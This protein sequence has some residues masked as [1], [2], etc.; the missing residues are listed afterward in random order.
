MQNCSRSRG[1]KTA[2]AKALGLDPPVSLLA[3]TD[4]VIEWSGARLPPLV[5]LLIAVLDH[6]RKRRQRRVQRLARIPAS[7][8]HNPEAKGSTRLRTLGDDLRQQK[9]ATARV[10]VAVFQRCDQQYAQLKQHEVGLMLHRRYQQ[11]EIEVERVA[12]EREVQADGL[13]GGAV[14]HINGIG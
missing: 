7:G 3:R 13:G 11:I 10:T 8:G 5:G 12:R 1:I 6:P 14:S 2:T 9:A 4:E